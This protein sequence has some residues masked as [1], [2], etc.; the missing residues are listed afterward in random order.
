MLHHLVVCVKTYY[1]FWSK[2]TESFL[3]YIPRSPKVHRCQVA[4]PVV[5]RLDGLGFRFCV[6]FWVEFPPT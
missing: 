4:Q 1:S 5:S 3:V 2:L 6:Q